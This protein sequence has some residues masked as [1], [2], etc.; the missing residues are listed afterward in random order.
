[1]AAA[2]K[3]CKKVMKASVAPGPFALEDAVTLTYGQV[4]RQE[5]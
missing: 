2:E 4:K 3:P 5:T 1:M